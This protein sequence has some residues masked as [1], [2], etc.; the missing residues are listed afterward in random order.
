MDQWEIIY[1]TALTG[2]ISALATGL[3]AIPVHFVQNNSKV[4]RA[5]ACS[6]AAGM[7]L[8]ASVFSL[9]QE[10]IALQ[11]K[12]FFGAI[13]C[14]HRASFGSRVFSLHRKELHQPYYYKI[15]FK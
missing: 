1:W 6:I 12:F 13:R 7:M 2:I 8:S 15:L 3:G 5:F 4:M 11:S 10:G 14:Y 9:V